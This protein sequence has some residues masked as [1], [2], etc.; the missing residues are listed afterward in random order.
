MTTKRPGWS[1][2]L[3][4]HRASLKHV[5]VDAGPMAYLDV[6]PRTGPAVVL[7]HGMPTSSWLYRRVAARLADDGV[8]VVAP[9]LPGFGASVKPTDPVAYSLSAQAGRLAL[10]LD[11]LE[12][13]SAVFACHDL[14]GPWVFEA[15]ADTAP[16]RIGGLVVL[17]TSAY[18]EPHDCRHAR[19][20][21]WAARSVRSSWG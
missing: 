10:L 8:R 20:D 3:E 18:A 7:V 16:Q 5:T 9:D 11:H 12:L 6:G 17:N 1:P 19:P 14:G 21:W 15:T 2:E 4:A 13:G